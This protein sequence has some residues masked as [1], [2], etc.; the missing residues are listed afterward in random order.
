[1]KN[2]PPFGARFF[3]RAG[4]RFLCDA[5]LMANFSLRR[6]L[7][8]V[9]STCAPSVAEIRFAVAINVF[10]MLLL[11]EGHQPGKA[12]TTA[13]FDALAQHGLEILLTERTWQSWFS[14][15]P[16]TPKLNKVRVLDQ[17]AQKIGAFD[18]H[19]KGQPSDALANYFEEMVFG[20]LITRMTHGTKSSRS[21]EVILCERANRYMPLSTLHLHLD[22]LETASWVEDFGEVS[23]SAIKNLAAE[24]ILGLLSLLWKR[25]HGLMYGDFVWSATPP[26]TRA[27]GLALFHAYRGL[28]PAPDAAYF[29]GGRE[30]AWDRIG[31]VLE[32][33][34]APVHKVMFSLARDPEFLV[35][36]KLL[37]WALDLS[38]AALAL[39][40][41]TW[42]RRYDDFGVFPSEEAIFWAA[43]DAI[44]FQAAAP[45]RNN[46][47]VVVA[48]SRC[49]DFWTDQDF[50]MFLWGRE[51]YRGLVQA[52]GVDINKLYVVAMRATEIHPM[53]FV[54]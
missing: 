19:G 18:G 7:P 39:Q 34:S 43:L 6:A 50:E 27:S 20:G 51:T 14:P 38:T 29:F 33:G 36:D 2:L 53:E 1:M 47:S 26:S 32:L 9:T 5:W 46:H 52:A 41:S 11:G 22:A 16:G 25:R 13:V 24:R 49:H 35:D 30:P 8:D 3:R 54:G 44:F 28:K 23:W 4:L 12:Q 45:G 15:N 48:M 10:K 37:A 21:L 17:M 42:C 31:S 40:A